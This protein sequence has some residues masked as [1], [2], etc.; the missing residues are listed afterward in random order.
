MPA[1]QRGNSASR[2]AI[3]AIVFAFPADVPSFQATTAATDRAPVAPH[4]SSRSNSA[5]I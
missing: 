5:T 3:V 2:C 1:A 4:N